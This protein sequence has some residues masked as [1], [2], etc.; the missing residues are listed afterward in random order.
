M[1]NEEFL[2]LEELAIKI[3]RSVNTLKKHF[4][5]TQINMAKKGIYI[6]RYGAGES[7]KYTISY[8]EK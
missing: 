6:N 7:G 1:A 5:R 8:K 3:N 4:E 2:T